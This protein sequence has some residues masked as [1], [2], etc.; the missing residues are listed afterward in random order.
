MGYMYVILSRHF[1]EFCSKLSNFSCLFPR[2]IFAG[3]NVRRNFAEKTVSRAKKGGGCGK[4]T[5]DLAVP[6]GLRGRVLPP[7]DDDGDLVTAALAA[8]VLERQRHRRAGVDL[9]NHFRSE[10]TNKT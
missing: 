8:R 3:K 5:P 6:D 7:S 1:C 2:E 4:S 9:M 10:F